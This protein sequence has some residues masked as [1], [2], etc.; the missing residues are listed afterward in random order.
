M[1][2]RTIKPGFFQNEQLADLP[3][4]DRLLFAGLWCIAD[5]AGRIEDRPRKIRA[6]L[7]PYENVDCDAML[8]SLAKAGFVTRYQVDDVRVVQVVNFEKHQNP[9]PR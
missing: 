2:S 8:D 5:K 6:E 3:A 9:H 1:R 7:F 4:L